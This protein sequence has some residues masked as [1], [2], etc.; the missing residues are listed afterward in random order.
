MQNFYV[1]FL[2]HPV[3]DGALL[4]PMCDAENALKPE[5]DFSKLNEDQEHNMSEQIKLRL[6]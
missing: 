3:L 2:C 6:N 4:W 1:C 5:E